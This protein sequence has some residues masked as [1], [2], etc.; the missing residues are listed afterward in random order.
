VAVI[1][2]RRDID[3][4][5]AHGS[6]AG[7]AAGLALG[8]TAVIG[9]L[10]LNGSAGTP[11]RFA[12]AFVVGPEAFQADFPLAAAV[13][14]ATVIHFALAALFGVLFLGLLS[15]TYQLSARPWLLVIYGALFAFGVWDVNFLAA[16]PT[17]FP[18]LAGRLDVATQVW[19]GIVSYVLVYGPALGLY[20]A[21]VRPGVVGD[22]HAVGA[23][24]G[25]FEQP[26]ADRGEG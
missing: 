16:V 8:A 19:T 6:L 13:L 23:P 2:E 5:V 26:P 20:V 10:A 15:L 4:V 17:F 9:S 3:T 24:A 11:F 18:F 7:L 12:S 1:V 25:T 14:L 22:W 21:I